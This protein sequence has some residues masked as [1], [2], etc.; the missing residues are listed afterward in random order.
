MIR[1]VSRGAP[2]LAAAAFA[3]CFA[4]A[5]KDEPPAGPRPAIFHAQGE[6][7]GEPT[8]NGAILQSRLTAADAPVDG[9]V[10]GMRGV[11]CFEISTVPDFAHFLRTPWMEAQPENDFIVKTRIDRLKPGTRYYYRLVYGVTRD[12]LLRGEPCTF[13]TLADS[14]VEAPVSFVVVTGMN[15][16]F[17]HH[18]RPNSPETAYAGPDKASGYPALEAIL[19]MAPDF[20][21]G[22]GDNVYY[23]HPAETRARTVSD[24]RRKWREQFV[25]ERFRR[26]FARVPTYWEKDDH[27]YRYNDADTTDVASTGKPGDPA[28]P[29]HALGVAVFREQLPVVDPADDSARTYRTHRINRLLQIWL[30]EGRDY[31]SPNYMEDG[32][33]KTLWGAEQLA[34]LKETLL[35]SDA[36]FK[37]LI[38][39]TPLVG[40]DDAYKIDNHV[41]R[42]GFRR[43]GEEFFRWLGDNGF[44]DRNFYLVCGDRHWQY[45]SAHPSGFEEFS[46]GAL[47]DANSRLGRIPGDPKSTDP[48]AEITQFYTQ[49]EASGGFLHV[50]VH[51]G[52][53]GSP[54]T[55]VFSFHDERGALLYSTTK[56]AHK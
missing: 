45:H 46:C 41:N 13:T 37:L 19:G 7:A 3:V 55:A 26:L 33:G 8:R 34:W 51:P 10:P 35:A 43:E 39:P 38:S 6:M 2:Y 49:D 14:T 52:A 21:V 32:P 22:T 15:Y 28:I 48:D 47:V 24:M 11:A 56:T 29:S 18:G 42:A 5:E 16:S 36:T 40:P 30:M 25:Q 23:D 31:R 54:P 20:F 9:D 44:L 53:G 50:E 4:C 17:F 12:S 1:Y 27:D